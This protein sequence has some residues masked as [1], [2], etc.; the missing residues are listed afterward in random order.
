MEP[1]SCKRCL[2][3]F[4]TEINIYDEPA[5]QNDNIFHKNGGNSSLETSYTKV[6]ADLAISCAVSETV[7][8]ALSRVNIKLELYNEP[9]RPK[10]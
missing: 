7:N 2:G 3:P 1:R 4:R 6:M 10:R 8:A 9:A 5:R